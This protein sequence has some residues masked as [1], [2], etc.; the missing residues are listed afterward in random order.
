MQITIW[1][2]LISAAFGALVGAAIGH[3]RQQLATGVILGALFGPFGWVA[4]FLI[5]RGKTPLTVPPEVR[6][7]M[8]RQRVA[9]ADPYA[10]WEA[11]ERRRELRASK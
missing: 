2:I 6:A 11:E 8:E 7:A 4:M 9:A 3:Y 5:P 1:T 10:Q